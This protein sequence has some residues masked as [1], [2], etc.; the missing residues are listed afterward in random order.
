MREHK[1]AI[2]GATGVVGRKF[3]EILEER[4][5]PISELRLLASPKSAGE[6]LKFVDKEIPVQVLNETS[7]SGIDFAFFSAGAGISERFVPIA[8]DSGATV[9]DNSSAFRMDKN[10]PLVVPEVNARALEVH[11]RIIANPNCSTIQMVVAANPL[12]REA[13]I[14][15]IVVSTYQSVSGKGR[16]AIMDLKDQTRS[17]LGGETSPEN[18]SSSMVFNLLPHIDV[19]VE[20][21]QTKE[22]LK[23]VQETRKIFELPDLRI[24]ATCVRVPVVNC[25]SIS[26]NLEFERPISPEQACDILSQ[27]P[28]VVVMDN[29]SEGIY[30]TPV[31]ASG[32]D[33]VFVGRIRK[34][35]SSQYG[36]NLW[37]VSDNLRKGAALN[38]VQIAEKLI[39]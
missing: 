36:L 2:V 28:G 8:A 11:D 33:A 32:K 39:G 37:V 9:I 20:D 27:S 21:N 5:F 22:E 25:H 26:L 6:R 7:F 18:E 3:V 16:K 31:Q 35:A 12:H 38:A 34:D 15:R 29:P 14:R 1:V 30:P 19:F 17:Y 10:V 24:S 4:R 23:M 13:S